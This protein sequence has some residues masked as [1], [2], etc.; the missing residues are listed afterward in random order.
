MVDCGIDPHCGGG[1][2]GTLYWPSN[3]KQREAMKQGVP[4]ELII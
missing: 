4:K 1:G 3:A 2:V